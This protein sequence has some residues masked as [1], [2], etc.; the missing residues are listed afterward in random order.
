MYLNSLIIYLFKH[1]SEPFKVNVKILVRA[2][3]HPAR[4]LE[5][6]LLSDFVNALRFKIISIRHVLTRGTR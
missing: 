3:A 1:H 2:A 5:P 4:T 6:P